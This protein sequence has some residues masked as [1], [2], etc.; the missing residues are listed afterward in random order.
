M[1]TIQ[2]ITNQAPVKAGAISR[3]NK[4]P[5]PKTYKK[6]SDKRVVR[7]AKKMSAAKA[8]GSLDKNTDT[9]ILTYGQF[10]LI[11][12]IMVILDQTGSAD[13]C[14]ST[15]TAA[16]AHLDLSEELM[17]SSDIRSLKM[18]VDRSFKTRQPKYFNRMVKLFGVN[19]IRE[20]RTHAKFI[21]VR[22]DNWDIVVRTS[23]N[24]NENPRLENLEISHD[25][26]F[27][28]FFDEIVDNIFEEVP[29]SYSKSD[30]LKLE[31]VP[32]DCPYKPVQSSHIKRR[33]LN[34]VE[35]THEIKNPRDSKESLFENNA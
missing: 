27:A 23:M 3:R 26:G 17:A 32:E 5:K 2:V 11:D 21:T 20:I 12:A 28:D 29:P 9:F 6:A 8:I 19:C 18:V 13:V 30:L 15:W 16:H 4:M 24:L 10:S 35:T 25:K 22:N 7:V 14:I 31:Q 33:K 34:E 1:K